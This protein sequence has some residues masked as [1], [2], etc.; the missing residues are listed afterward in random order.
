MFTHL[1]IVSRNIDVL[2]RIKPQEAYFGRSSSSSVKLV[3]E[4]ITIRV[5]NLIAI[6]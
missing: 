4:E 2:N 5:C 6:K 1:Y 3:Q